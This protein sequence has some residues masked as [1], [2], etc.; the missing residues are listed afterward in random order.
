[1]PF[2]FQLLY[3]W[4]SPDL[5][6]G[7]ERQISPVDLFGADFATEKSWNS[8][9]VR[10]AF[11][12]PDSKSLFRYK[13]SPPSNQEICRFLVKSFL[14]SGSENQIL[15]SKFLSLHLSFVCLFVG[16]FGGTGTFVRIFGW[17]VR[18]VWTDYISPQESSSYGWLRRRRS[19]GIYFTWQTF[20]SRLYP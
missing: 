6:G 13:S 1:M 17:Q 8:P 2:T 14:W 16:S 19:F 15:V 11:K 18:Q 4:H 7:F 10:K 12:T 5:P 20:G 9:A 3:K